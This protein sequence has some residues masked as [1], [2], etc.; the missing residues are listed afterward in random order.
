MSH[1]IHFEYNHFRSYI[2]RNNDKIFVVVNRDAHTRTFVL[3]PYSRTLRTEYEKYGVQRA[4]NFS[5][6][7]TGYKELVQ[8]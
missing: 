4:Y 5:T 1:K 3:A 8:F 7:S 2:D 6:G